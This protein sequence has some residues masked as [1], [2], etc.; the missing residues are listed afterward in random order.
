MR[1]VVV[2][3]MGIV[4]CIGN[5]AQEVVASLREGR[6]G[7]GLDPQHVELGFRSHVSGRPK[8]DLDEAV[9]R[10]HRRFMGDGAAYNY[11]A[12]EQAIR[13]SGLE[14]GDVVNERTG[15]IMGSGGPST[16]NIVLAC[17]TA[18][19]KGPKRVGPFMVP[20]AMS[21]TNSATLSTF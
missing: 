3:G 4:S 21:S 19:E 17:D 6:S 14:E 9:D 20:R 12:M 10:R 5:S 1:R 13:D 7:I 11:L 18:R 15:L 2:T 8:V 16:K